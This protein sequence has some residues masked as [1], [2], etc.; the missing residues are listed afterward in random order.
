M[1]QPQEREGRQE[2]KLQNLKQLEKRI[3]QGM[4]ANAL[5][6]PGLQIRGLLL[7]EERRYV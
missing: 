3:A 4:W 7:L 1:L 2:V 5:N 6:M